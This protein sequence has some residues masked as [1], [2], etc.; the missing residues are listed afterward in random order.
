[1]VKMGHRNKHHQQREQGCLA[2]KRSCLYF[3]VCKYVFYYSILLCFILFSPFSF[4]KTKTYVYIVEK[5]ASTSVHMWCLFTI[6]KTTTTHLK[7]T[8]APSSIG[9]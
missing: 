2:R 7:V 8:I 5:K 6:F 4:L 9:I 3:L 1:M